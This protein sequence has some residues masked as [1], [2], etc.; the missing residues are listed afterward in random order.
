MYSSA[1]GKSVTVSPR[2]STGNTEPVWTPDV[3]I[4]VNDGTTI[5]SNSDMIVNATCKRC[6][7][8][9]SGLPSIQTS[10][11][12]PIMFAV[13]PSLDLNSDDLDARIRRHAAY[14]QTTLD[15][16]KAVG[17]G[18][19]ALDAAGNVSSPAASTTLA[20]DDLHSD[21]DPAAWA[22]GILYAV[23]A[24]ALAPLDSLVAGALGRR[25]PCV[26]GVSASLYFAFVIGAMVPGVLV[27]REHVLTQQYRTPHQVI[28][29]LTVVAMAVMFL[30]GFALSWITR[31][32]KRRG[33]QPPEGTRLLA[34][35]H[36]WVSRLIWVLLLVNVGLGM[37]LSEEKLALCLAYAAL[38]LGVVVILIPVYFCIWRC[39]KHK[40]KKDETHELTI[41]DHH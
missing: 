1:D 14:G 6:R 12:A 19:I 40:E 13:G 2:L 24:L 36:R 20:R 4:A 22:H 7:A 23:V 28:G 5:N 34:A 15:L 9:G 8:L 39:L 35:V 16:S 26:H 29:L 27:S 18:G 38:A 11:A 37:K 17:P 32:A 30:W 10:A 21:G 3:H 41:Y 31:A 33:Q 25:W